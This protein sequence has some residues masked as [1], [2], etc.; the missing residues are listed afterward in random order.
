MHTLTNSRSQAKTTIS[1]GLTCFIIRFLRRL[2]SDF[3]FIAAEGACEGD[4]CACIDLSRVEDE[5]I[6]DH[7]GLP[8]K[9]PYS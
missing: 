9:V 4:P 1:G 6:I 5:K 2:Q 7:W 3:V 8:A